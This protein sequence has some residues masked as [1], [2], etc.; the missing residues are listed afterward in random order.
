ICP[1]STRPRSGS[2]RRRPWRSR[3]PRFLR[4]RRN[5]SRCRRPRLNPRSR[6]A[7]SCG[8]DPASVFPFLSRSTSRSI[9]RSLAA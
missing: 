1:I 3:R 2:R 7:T 6:K 8:R 5:R 9:L 4:P